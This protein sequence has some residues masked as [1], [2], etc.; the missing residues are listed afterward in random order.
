MSRALLLAILAVLVGCGPDATDTRAVD[1]PY[2]LLQG[3]VQD[4]VDGDTIDALPR[5][6]RP[7]RVRYEG[8]DAPEKGQPGGR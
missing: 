8:I 3:V 4:I 7:F 6:H 1:Y 5:D 2:P